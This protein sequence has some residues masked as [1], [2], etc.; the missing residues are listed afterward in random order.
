M[1]FPLG[2]YRLAVR[3]LATSSLACGGGESVTA[4]GPDPEPEP[5]APGQPE[6][7]PART[8]LGTLGGAVSYA[9]DI[10]DR[11]TVVGESETASGDFHAFRWTPAGGLQDLAP[12]PGDD[13]SVAVAVASDDVVLGYSTAPDLT[14]RP[15]SWT[16]DGV[17]NE[18]AIAGPDGAQLYPADRNGQGTVVG[19]A[20]IFGGDDPQ[21]HA[22]VWSGG[23]GFLD[24]SNVL[25]PSFQNSATG[26][27]ERGDVTATAGL[28]TT[29]GYRWNATGGVTELG[30]PGNAPDATAVAAAAVNAQGAV[31]GSTTL[32]DLGTG[33]PGP[34]FP[35]F[36]N[37]P[38]I[39]REGSGF[40]LLPVFGAGDDAS[41]SAEDI[42][43][44]SDVVGAAFV[45]SSG[46][47][48]AVAWPEAGGIVSLNGPDVSTSFALAVNNGR[49]AAGY[50]TLPNGDARGTVWN[51]AQAPAAVASQRLQRQDRSGLGRASDLGAVACLWRR[52]ALSTKTKLFACLEAAQAQ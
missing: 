41:G 30:V 31:V 20:I 28:G 23:T 45:A 4:P 12:L 8:D 48:Q 33:P 32:E 46:T 47:L 51:L 3:L 19:E 22:W 52:T 50:T 24:L 16:P 11:N 14:I 18:L 2:P 36:R 21:T 5:P 43:D 7:L 1:R 40:T 15:V 42:N 49:I 25:E 37:Q 26:I 27:N 13:E 10:N 44:A 29:R 9:Y 35:S 38:F 6:P 39:W 34:P 17:V